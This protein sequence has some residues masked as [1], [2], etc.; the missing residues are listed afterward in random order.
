LVGDKKEQYEWEVNFHT[1]NLI[2][3]VI[4][5]PQKEPKDNKHLIIKNIPLN[6]QRKKGKEIN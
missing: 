5:I 2:N 3:I 4:D 1:A 6:L